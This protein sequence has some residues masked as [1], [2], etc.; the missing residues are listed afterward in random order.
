MFN[1]IQTGPTLLHLNRRSVS[2]MSQHSAIV[3]LDVSDL[4]D[5][6]TPG[7]SRRSSRAS[8]MASKSRKE[9]SG[10]DR[11][12]KVSLDNLQTFTTLH[13]ATEKLRICKRLDSEFKFWRA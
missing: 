11:K 13:C 1:C 2:P 8:S 4:G 5:A 3:T 7:A 12:N 6:L 10:S 9:S